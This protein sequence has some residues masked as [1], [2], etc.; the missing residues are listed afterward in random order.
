MSF[1]LSSLR[2]DLSRWSQD[3]MATV[4]WVAIPLMI[5]GLITMLMGSDVKPQ[6]TL[7]LV[8]EDETVLSELIV[9]AY[10]AGELGELI[11]VE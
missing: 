8:D 9:G 10:S 1:A 3:Y 7:L 6:G 4:T 11:S 2:K 5:G